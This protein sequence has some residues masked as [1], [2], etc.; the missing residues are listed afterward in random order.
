MGL[1]IELEC[2]ACGEKALVAVTQN[3]APTP[4][5]FIADEADTGQGLL[6]ELEKQGWR[7][8]VVKG[9]VVAAC[10]PAH[11]DEATRRLKGALRERATSR[12]TKSGAHARRFCPECGKSL[13]VDG[14]DTRAGIVC[15]HCGAEVA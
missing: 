2:D 14:I 11:F 10:C 12:A 3:P 15:P 7:L 6:G 4:E 8:Q 5:D 13:G 9:I 1:R